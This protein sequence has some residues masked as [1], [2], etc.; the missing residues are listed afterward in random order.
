MNHPTLTPQSSLVF[1]VDGWT[2][3]LEQEIQQLLAAAGGAAEAA[4]YHLKSGGRRVRA[5]LTWNAAVA[6]GLTEADAMVLATVVECLHSASL[7][8]DDLQ[9]DEVLRH[10]IPT[11][12]AAYGTNI[13]ICT[14]D[15]FISA[16]YAGLVKF[17]RPN[18]LPALISAVHAATSAA[19]R[20]Q[21]A[22]FEPPQDGVEGLTKYKQVAVDKSGALLSLPLE[23]AFLAAEKN[24]W[25]PQAR[26]AAEEFAVG[27][28][29]MDDLADAASDGPVAMNVVVVLRA[30]GQAAEVAYQLGIQH[31]TTAANLA[32]E[33]PHQAGELLRELALALVASPQI[34]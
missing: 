21:C 19:I 15:L 24:E 4:N 26:R 20:G 14:G 9:D 34:S 13:A 31:L 29:I 3:E 27:Y 17:S 1:G 22:G 5:R 30:Q 28:Q 25:L 8:H 33:L 16:A 10:G 32:A 18:L 2:R 23:L 7:V 12:A 6:L 11:A